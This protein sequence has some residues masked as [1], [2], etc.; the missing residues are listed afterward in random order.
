MLKLI[1]ETPE[2]MSGVR[3]FLLVF[4]KDLSGDTRF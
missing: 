4:I 1:V 3:L 2:K